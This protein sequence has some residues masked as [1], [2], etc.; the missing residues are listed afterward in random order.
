MLE[1]LIGTYRRLD[2]LKDDTERPFLATPGDSRLDMFRITIR[3]RNR[4][5]PGAIALELSVL[6]TTRDRLG[7]TSSPDVYDELV[8][9]KKTELTRV[10]VTVL[11]K[12]KVRS[13]VVARSECVEN[14]LPNTGPGM[15]RRGVLGRI[16]VLGV[17]GAMGIGVLGMGVLGVGVVKALGV[18]VVVVIGVV[19]GILLVGVVIGILVVGMG[20]VGVL[21]VGIGLGIVGK[22]GLVVG[23]L[24]LGNVG[25]GLGRGV[26][27]RGVGMGL[28]NVVMGV[29]VLG[30]GVVVALRGVALSMAELLM[31]LPSPVVVI[32][33][34]RLYRA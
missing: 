4:K 17:L 18:G 26:V 13:T 20:V 16:G 22:V 33:S 6:S 11:T 8:D 30:R 27:V 14:S 24:V 25:V 29:G 10:S 23:R 3:T 9:K 5:K 21:R 32:V 19:V 12:L 15:N 7:I 34:A 1:R 2:M 31:P 28:G